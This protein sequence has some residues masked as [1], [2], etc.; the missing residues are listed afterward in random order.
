VGFDQGFDAL[1]LNDNAALR[2][3]VDAM[4]TDYLS[5]VV[6]VDN[7]LRLRTNASLPQFNQKCATIYGFDKSGTE[8][9]VNLNNCFYD[10]AREVITTT[11]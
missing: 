6:D 11:V 2:Q 1:E 5:L 3:E 9:L 10:A 7:D 8:N 4:L